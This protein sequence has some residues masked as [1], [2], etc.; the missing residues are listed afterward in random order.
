MGGKLSKFVA[1]CQHEG[2]QS[3]PASAHT[4]YEYLAFLSLEG[5]IQPRYWT[6][7]GPYW[8]LLGSAILV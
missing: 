8:I 2:V 4:V 3:V 6:L 1:F 5:A 7:T